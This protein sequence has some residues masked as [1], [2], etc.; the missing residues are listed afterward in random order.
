MKASMPKIGIDLVAALLFFGVTA[1]HAADVENGKLLY[2]ACLA[3]H[4]DSSDALGPS[5]KG[6]FGRKSGAVADY[7]YSAPMLRANLVWD[8]PNLKAFIG[9]PQA[10]VKGTRMPFGG[11]SLASDAEDLVVYLKVLQ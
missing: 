2:G 5:L 10:K 4:A 9:N 1:T 3:C 8:E 11:M 6:V 7:R